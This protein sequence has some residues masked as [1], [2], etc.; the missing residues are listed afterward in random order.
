MR[1]PL[2]ALTI[3]PLVGN[4]LIHGCERKSGE[5]LIAI[6]LSIHDELLRISARDNGIGMDEAAQANLR[7]KLA[8]CDTSAQDKGVGCGIGLVNIQRRI[9]LIFSEAYG[10]ALD[11]AVGKGTEITLLLPW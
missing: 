5:I 3:Q 10:L 4:A 2:P 9:H 8:Q 1:Y 7:K 11:S 6:D